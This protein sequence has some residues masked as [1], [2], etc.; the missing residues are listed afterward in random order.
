MQCPYLIVNGKLSKVRNMFG[1]LHQRVEL[2]LA[3]ELELGLHVGLLAG[4]GLV[5]LELVAHP[6]GLEDPLCGHV[7]RTEVTVLSLVLGLLPAL[8]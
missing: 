2:L 5:Q 4:A 1:P 3:G 8:A 6:F 7:A